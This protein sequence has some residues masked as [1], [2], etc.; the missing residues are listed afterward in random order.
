MQA[1]LKQDVEGKSQAS[2][3][4]TTENVPVD[5]PVPSTSG[6][7]P[8]QGKDRKSLDEQ[9]GEKQKDS[10]KKEKRYKKTLT[11]LQFEWAQQQPEFQQLRKKLL[12]KYQ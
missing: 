8:Q 9:A 1:K 7:Q 2:A 11:C 12:R 6:K 10:K 4:K 5:N 3:M